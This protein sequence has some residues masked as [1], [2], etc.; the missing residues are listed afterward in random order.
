MVVVAIGAVLLGMALTS[1]RTMI[2]TNRTKGAAESILSGLRLARSEAI[3]RNVP[4]RFQLVTTLT[5]TC[6]YSTS[7]T[8]W[9]VT[10]TD[11]V[12]RGQVAGYCDALPF[13]PP[14]Q[15]D[16]CSPAPTMPT[17][18]STTCANDPLIAYKSAAGTS[19]SD[20]NLVTSADSSIITFGPLGQV[21]ANIE[22][23]AAITQVD[24]SST[25]P[26]A[27]AWRVRVSPTSGAVKLCD[28]SLAAGQPLAC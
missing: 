1:F 7:S 18:T 24:I 10:Q 3:K 13:M 4:M 20:T 22:G 21:L 14:D 15:P 26:D 5:S 12:A 28:P 8:L 9:V 25:N 6:T 17:G 2:D 16:I 19:N 11:Q 27:K 23:T